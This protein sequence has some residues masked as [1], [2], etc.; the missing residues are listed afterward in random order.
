MKKFF[1]SFLSLGLAL[2]LT[3]C[4]DDDDTTT[5]G[6]TSNDDSTDN[7]TT[8]V[9]ANNIDYADANATSWGN[10]MQIVANLLVEDSETLLADWSD[11]YNGGQ[12]YATFFKA[13]DAHTSIGQLIDVCAD[14]SN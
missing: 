6:T 11:S 14:I 9:D 13:Q 10:Y 4:G 7:T 2:S 8:V 3:D 5:G 12:S 1:L